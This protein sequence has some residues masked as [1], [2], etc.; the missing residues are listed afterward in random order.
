VALER[1]FGRPLS[2]VERDW[3]ARLSSSAGGTHVRRRRGYL[4]EL[5]AP[6]DDGAA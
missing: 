2:E 1:A 4:Y 6:G 3:R 5:D